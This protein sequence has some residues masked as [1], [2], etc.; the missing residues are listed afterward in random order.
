[1]GAVHVNDWRKLNEECFDFCA[2]RERFAMSHNVH[3]AIILILVPVAFF[4][5]WSFPNV[6]GLIAAIATLAVSIFLYY[7]LRR[8]YPWLDAAR[9]N[10]PTPKV[11]A[12]S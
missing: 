4:W 1:M 3:V 7:L 11:K 10:P 12:P 8:K 5:L 9:D 6:P 2:R